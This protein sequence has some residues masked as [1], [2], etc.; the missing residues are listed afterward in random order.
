MNVKTLLSIT[1]LA[2][3]G[4]ALAGCETAKSGGGGYHSTSSEQNVGSRSSHGL[5]GGTVDQTGSAGGGTSGTRQP[6]AP[7]TPYSNRAT[8]GNGT[9]PAA[10][11]SP[12]AGAAPVPPGGPNTGA[13]PGTG[14]SSGPITTPPR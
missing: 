7:T 4:V 3:S 13:D 14:N 8:P 11:G 5:Y 9:T 1:A 10:P 12:G 6:G 2:V